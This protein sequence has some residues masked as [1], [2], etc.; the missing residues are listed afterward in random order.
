MIESLLNDKNNLQ[1]RIEQL[2]KEK[3]D[4]TNYLNKCTKAIEEKYEIELKKNK[5]AWMA[6]EKN[7]R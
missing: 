4:E 1:S 5:E 2:V 6:S 7:R 3:K